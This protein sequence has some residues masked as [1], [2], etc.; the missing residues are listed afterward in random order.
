MLNRFE[1]ML[2]KFAS[3]SSLC[4]GIISTN[5]GPIRGCINCFL[6]WWKKNLFMEVQNAN[7]SRRKRTMES[8]V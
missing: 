6:I 4:H 5:Y 8:Y 2:P 7:V 1:Y 3:K